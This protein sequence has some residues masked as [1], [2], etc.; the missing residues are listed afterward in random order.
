MEFLIVV[1]LILL[2]GFFALSE[3]ALVS[4]K[5]LRL[6][7]LRD[8]E[9]N[10]GAKYALKLLTNSERFLSS[11]QVGITLIGIITGYYG[12]VSF[13]P[14][15]TPFFEWLHVPAAYS[16]QIAIVVSIA[17]ITFF[18]IVI[19]EL[20]PKSIALTNPE[21]AAVVV[22]P[23][24]YI[25][26]LIFSPIVK[27]L[28]FS[29][30]LC[31]KMLALNPP[32]VHFTEEELR[33]MLNVAYKEGVIE[34]EQNIIH[35]K[36][37]NFADKR[38]KHI[39]TH[40]SEIEWID[41][42]LPS[43]KFL[44]QLVQF[45]TSKIL[46]CDG[47]LENYLGILN[48]KEFLIEKMSN[49]TPNVQDLLISPFVCP[50]STDAQDILNEFQKRQVYFCIVVDEFGTVEGIVTL[51]DLVENIVGE[52]PEEEEI[53]EPDIF[54]REDNSVLVNG[55]APIEVLAE[56]IDHFEIDFDEIDY[57]TVA[58]FVLENIEKIPEVGDRFKFKNYQIE[59]V[60]IDH[61]RVDKVLI[62]KKL[63]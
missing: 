3:I 41:V 24:I 47:Q 8:E 14:Y 12:G 43:E 32:K 20:V 21:K 23:I 29:T 30:K 35:E 13:A 59:I 55:D 58:G 48:I 27:L 42:N 31:N 37:F 33:Q 18:S 53:V 61:N 63:A 56:V 50:E 62:T 60:D 5:K 40:R 46:V 57:S 11:I 49:P 16:T 22:A 36:L 9:N 10:K 26:S 51:H 1:I 6:E 28:A 38:A 44:T 4:S 15:L 39:M 54:V 19:G 52:L 45:K 7:H 34:E 25:F 17:L 2:N